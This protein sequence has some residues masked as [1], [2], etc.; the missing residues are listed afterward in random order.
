MNDN[1]SG[2]YSGPLVDEWLFYSREEGEFNSREPGLCLHL[3]WHFNLLK[4]ELLKCVDL[5]MSL[6]II[7]VRTRRRRRRF[8][9][10]PN[11]TKPP[12]LRPS[13][14]EDVTFSD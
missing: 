2:G 13:A 3:R 12:R 7:Q 1:E 4:Q 5:M 9:Q 6:K 8:S 14:P 10:P 11:T